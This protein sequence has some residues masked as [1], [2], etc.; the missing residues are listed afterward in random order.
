MADDDYIKFIRYGQHYIEKK[1]G[2]GNFG[3]YLKQLFYRWNNS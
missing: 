3:I 2:K 1:N